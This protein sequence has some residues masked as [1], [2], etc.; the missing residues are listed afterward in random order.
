MSEGKSKKK[1]AVIITEYRHNSHAEVIVGRLLEGL[2]YHPRVEVVSMYTDQVPDNDMSREAAKNKNVPIFPTIAEAIRVGDTGT[3]IDGVVIVGEHGDYPWNEKRQKEYPRKRLMAE[4]LQALDELEL[5]VPVFLDKHMSYDMRDAAWIYRQVKQRNIPFMGGSSVSLTESVPRFNPEAL[6]TAKEWFVISHGGIESYGYHAM[7]VL[8]H[9]AEQR[10]GGET[11]IASIHA[12]E[13][14]KVWE[15]MDRKEWPED[16]L[17]ETL[18]KQ[19]NPPTGHPRG[20]VENPVLFKI[21]YWDGSKGYVA[22]FGS[23]TRDWAFAFRN[24]EGITS[25]RCKMY[26]R[27]FKHFEYFTQK[28]EDL[29]IE[30]R[31]SFPMER[32]YVTTGLIDLGMESLHQKK[33]IETPELWIT[34]QGVNSENRTDQ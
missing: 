32:T 1:V 26:G 10:S 17:L 2:P 27:P 31:P 11:G 30:G 5:T 4:T 22:Q 12:L 9:L 19:E 16:L 34:Y 15:A 21:C 29:I 25:A 20:Q 23:F 8:Q 13:G 28:I 14:E 7:E 6:K 18:K 3:I 24:K 33:K